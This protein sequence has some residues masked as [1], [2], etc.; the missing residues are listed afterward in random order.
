ME[1]EGNNLSERLKFTLKVLGI[2]QTELAK[3]INVKPQIIQYLCTGNAEKSKF[4]FDIAE[5]LKIDVIWLATGKGTAPSNVMV[6]GKTEKTIP[7]FTFEQIKKREIHGKGIEQHEISNYISI[8]EDINA[9]AFA[10]ILNDKSMAPRFDLNTTIIIDPTID[11]FKTHPNNLFILVYLAT[12]DFIIFRK[13]EITGE[14]KTLISLN[15]SL[16]KNILLSTKD[17]II[18]ICKEARWNN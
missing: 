13:L 18:G 4:T 1:I 6:L 15:S 14:S 9:N 16:Y 10:F 2:T 3:K 11:I 7:I 12:E 8:K 17:I 5:A